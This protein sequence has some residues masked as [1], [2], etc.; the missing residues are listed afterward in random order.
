MALEYV[1]R[2]SANLEDQAIPTFSL[3]EQEGESDVQ[4]WARTVTPASTFGSSQ[5]ATGAT[6]GGNPEQSAESAGAGFLVLAQRPGRARQ[7]SS[8]RAKTS[9]EG[10]G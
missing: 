7:R 8:I 10:S 1:R 9:G 5:D 3:I 6:L 4:A 2:A